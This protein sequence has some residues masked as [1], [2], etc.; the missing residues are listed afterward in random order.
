MERILSP[1]VHQRRIFHAP[2]HKQTLGVVAQEIHDILH[3][4]TVTHAG[5]TLLG[6]LVHPV[7]A[8]RDVI[9]GDKVQS[10]R[11][12]VFSL[13]HVERIRHENTLQPGFPRTRRESNLSNQRNPVRRGVVPVDRLERY[14]QLLGDVH[15]DLHQ[16]SRVRLRV[17]VVAAVLEDALQQKH[18][19]RAAAAVRGE[20]VQ[21]RG[22]RRV[23]P[24]V[25]RE[26]Q[27]HEH[28]AVLPRFDELAL[29]AARL[30]GADDADGFVDAACKQRCQNNC[31]HKENKINLPVRINKVD[32]A[33]HAS[34]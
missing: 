30:R 12:R 10:P 9:P 2:L 33:I 20:H 23:A 16:R 7:L 28:A 19:R 29:R 34:G 13:E 17:F 25:L 5:C 18:S 15:L 8:L 21:T 3:A 32:S 6:T 1:A 11:S 27:R 14:P 22:F 4:H 24:H 26:R 31:L